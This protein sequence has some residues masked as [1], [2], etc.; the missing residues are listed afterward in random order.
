MS[1]ALNYI[2]YK[3]D[4]PIDFINGQNITADKVLVW[5]QSSKEDLI[6]NFDHMS[7]DIYIAGN[8]KFPFKEIKVRSGFKKC[9][10]FLSR[11]LYDKGNL[12]LLKII[13]QASVLMRFEVSVKAHPTSSTELFK[14]IIE[15]YHIKLLPASY[16]ISSILS[17]N[18]Y[19]FSV[20]YN[21]NA[22]YESM[23]NDLICFRYGVDENEGYPGLDDKFYDL[24]SF[25]QQVSIYRSIDQNKINLMLSDLL[26]RTIGMGINNYKEILEQ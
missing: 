24:E 12:E 15:Q 8:A 1:H 2:N 22:Y 11:S 17:D 6:R 23:Y 16:T 5:G 21:T 7:L 20:C 4:T 3:R 26:I 19:D 25:Q 10:V 13:G 9:I 14:D 18:E